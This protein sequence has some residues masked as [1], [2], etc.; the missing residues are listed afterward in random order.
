MC[1]VL[2]SIRLVCGSHI[3]PLRVQV[4]VD[5][6]DLQFSGKAQG[7]ATP[8]GWPKGRSTELVSR[9]SSCATR[10]AGV[11]NHHTSEYSQGTQSHREKKSETTY[12]GQQQ[13]TEIL[14][15]KQANHFAGLG[16]APYQR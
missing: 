9:S 5:L 14:R 16:I 8:S 11:T 2:S 10:R 4:A 1:G 7:P 3:A 6:S 13:S 12:P 15:T